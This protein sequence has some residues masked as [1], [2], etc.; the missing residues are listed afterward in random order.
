MYFVKYLCGSLSMHEYPVPG[1]HVVSWHTR[2]GDRLILRSNGRTSRRSH[3]KAANRSVL[4]EGQHSWKIP[5][6]CI[7]AARDQVVNRWR[8]STIRDVR[9]F[10]AGQVLEQLTA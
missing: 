2:L 5:E 8:S 10:D 7:N 4:H 9:H 3:S 1:C 6:I